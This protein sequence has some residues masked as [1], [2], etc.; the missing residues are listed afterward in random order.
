[1]FNLFVLLSFSEPLA[2]IAKVSHQKKFLFLNDKPCM[3]RPTLIDMSP[4]DLKYCLFV[5]SIDKCTGSCN[6]LSPEIWVP[7][8]P[9]TYIL[10]HLIW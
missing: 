3:G 7:K 10:K 8:E 6:I 5:T 9:K 4:V 2:R 1:M